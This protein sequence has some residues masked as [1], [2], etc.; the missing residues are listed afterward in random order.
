MFLNTREIEAML[1]VPPFSLN[2]GG[3]PTAIAID[4]NTIE[5]TGAAE[6]VT[7]VANILTDRKSKWSK[8]F[9][10]RKVHFEKLEESQ[11]GH[12]FSIRLKVK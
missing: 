7:D 4:E 6:Y 11:E 8:Y 3:R 1:S 5:I 2:Q 10:K 12:M 9:T